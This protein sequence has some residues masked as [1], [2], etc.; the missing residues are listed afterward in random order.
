MVYRIGFLWVDSFFI[1]PRKWAKRKDAL[2]VQQYAEYT[3][4]RV[5]WVSGQSNK[6]EIP[7]DVQD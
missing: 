1:D 6:K 5:C 3:I 7:H 2:S 4:G